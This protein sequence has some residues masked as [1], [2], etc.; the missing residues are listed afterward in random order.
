[1][2][3]VFTAR[4][5]A[6]LLQEGK[7]AAAIPAGAVL[8]PSARDAIQEWERRQQASRSA[9]PVAAK[10]EVRKEDKPTACTP[11][12]YRPGEEFRWRPGQDPAGQQQRADYYQS[13]PI[14]RLRQCAAQ[15]CSGLWQRGWA[16]G[17][18]R[19]VVRV[20]DTLLLAND[21]ACAGV[22]VAADDFLYH[23]LDGNEV[24]DADMQG[25]ARSL[26]GLEAVF[27]EQRAARVVL[28]A[29]PPYATAMAIAKTKP[30]ACTLA[31]AEVSVGVIGL[32]DG[33]LP[34]AAQYSHKL[35]QL[36]AKH[37]ALLLPYQGVVVWGRSIGE[38][39]ERLQQTETVCRSL[40]LAAP[41]AN[42]L[43]PMPDE[44]VRALL[45]SGQSLGRKDP[46]L[47]L[48]ECELCDNDEF[49]P[50]VV[51]RP[52]AVNEE[53]EQ[54]VRSLTDQIVRQLHR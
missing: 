46:R 13:E 9:Q 19:L 32:A 23:S 26:A 27:R 50:G 24:T 15:V 1:M 28:F 43:E 36:C 52:S 37:T 49:R 39:V 41:L 17:G 31:Q 25:T 54:I 42:R 11:K 33:L 40:A 45:E 8:T 7:S 3:K 12:P 10:A 44:T 38:A 53:A 4:D 20:A 48:K 29:T 18:L 34:G 14:S 51:C 16:D 6:K 30:P 35:G 21:D 47:D 22:S 5:F 2:R